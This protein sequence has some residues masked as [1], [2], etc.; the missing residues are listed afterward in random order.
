MWNIIVNAINHSPP[1]GNANVLTL[2]SGNKPLTYNIDCIDVGKRASCNDSLNTDHLNALV[3]DLDCCSCTE[4]YLKF[5]Y[6]SELKDYRRPISPDKLYRMILDACPRR[7]IDANID[8]P[9]SQLKSELTEIMNI[10][11]LLETIN[12]TKHVL[13]CYGECAAENYRRSVWRV[14]DPYVGT[15]H[16][17]LLSPLKSKIKTGIVFTNANGHNPIESEKSHC[18]GYLAKH[19]FE[20]L[21]PQIRSRCTDWNECLVS[22]EL[23]LNGWGFP[24]IM[25]YEQAIATKNIKILWKRTWKS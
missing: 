23:L 25:V 11:F 13:K 1:P 21:I 6:L 7:D 18:A 12:E 19:G 4:D 3:G 8:M 24:S 10:G 16:F 5:P 14:E 2:G 9:Q 22:R 20:V 17:I 15:F